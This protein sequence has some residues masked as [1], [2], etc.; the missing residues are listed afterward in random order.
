[1]SMVPPVWSSKNSSRL[2]APALTGR[3]KSGLGRI[4]SCLYRLWVKGME[5]QQEVVMLA[6]LVLERPL[7]CMQLTVKLKPCA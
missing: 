1:M 4:K 2:L 6:R 3:I 5:H 7:P